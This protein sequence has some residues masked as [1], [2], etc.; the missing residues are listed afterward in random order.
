[1][2]YAWFLYALILIV[3]MSQLGARKGREIPSMPPRLQKSKRCVEL[4]ETRNDP[5]LV[6]KSKRSA[7]SRSFNLLLI[8][9]CSHRNFSFLLHTDLIIYCHQRQTRDVWGA[10]A[11]KVAIHQV[12]SSGRVLYRVSIYRR[13]FHHHYPPQKPVYYFKEYNNMHWKHLCQK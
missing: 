12:L 13:G 3:F 6:S 10:E 4:S 1:M 11:Q 5:S 8:F 7:I 2:V 9:S